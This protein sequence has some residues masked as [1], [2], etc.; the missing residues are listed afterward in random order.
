MVI[1]HC[2]VSSPEG[3]QHDFRYQ[4]DG[5]SPA[6]SPQMSLKAVNMETSIAREN[7]DAMVLYKKFGVASKAVRTTQKMNVTIHIWLCLKIGFTLVVW[8][9]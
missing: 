6:R 4:Q 1:F 8:P 2:Y 3:I 5:G 7:I 9:F